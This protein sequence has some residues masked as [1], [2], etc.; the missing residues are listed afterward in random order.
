MGWNQLREEVWDQQFSPPIFVFHHN[1]INFPIQFLQITKSDAAIGE[2]D[3]KMA[4]LYHR[5][6]PQTSKLQRFSQQVKQI[7]QKDSKGVGD[8][9]IRDPPPETTIHAVTVIKPMCCLEK[10]ASLQSILQST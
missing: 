3:Q 9:A 7:I 5:R 2:Q 4:K 6:K 8:A 1:Q 10:F